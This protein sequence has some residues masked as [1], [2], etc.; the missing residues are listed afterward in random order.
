MPITI[1][2]YTW[3]ESESSVYITLPLHNLSRN[4]VDILYTP[5]Y[6]KVSYPPY[7]FEI[8]LPHK[9]WSDLSFEDLNEDAIDTLCDDNGVKC[10]INENKIFL[11]LSKLKPILWNDLFLKLDKQ[12]NQDRRTEAVKWRHKYEELLARKKLREERARDRKAVS[13]SIDQDEMYRNELKAKKERIKSDFFKVENNDVA[14]IENGGNDNE[15]AGDNS[16]KKFQN[17]H[18]SKSKTSNTTRMIIERSNYN[19]ALASRVAQENERLRDIPPPRNIQAVTKPSDETLTQTTRSSNVITTTFTPKATR[20]PLREGREDEAV[21]NEM[22]W[23]KKDYQQRNNLGNDKKQEDDMEI[24]DDNPLES[25]CQHL[26][27]KGEQFFKN[28]DFASAL[29]VFTHGIQNVNSMFAPFHNN[30]GAVHLKVGNLHGVITDC[31]RA[32]ELLVP[33]CPSN[34]LQRVKAHMR[35]GTGN[36]V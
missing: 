7:M 11:E 4:K 17:N 34:E 1:K 9:I 8:F 23:K 27:K 25:D 29:E 6:L 21:K 12:E 32:I 19:I 33:K 2:E 3:H 13:D 31:S 30:R 14:D 15:S 5:K 22:E 18:P 16:S 28:E 24:K 35:I 36:Y 20:A 26:L 10:L